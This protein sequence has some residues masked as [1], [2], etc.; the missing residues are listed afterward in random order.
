ATL[1]TLN[2]LLD[3]GASLVLAS[4]LGRPKGQVNEELRMAPVADRLAEL[5]GRDVAAVSDVVG[6]EARAVCDHIEPGEV[7]LLENL[8]FEPG[9]ERNDAGFADELAALADLYGDDAFGAAHR[10]HASVLAL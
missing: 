8:R 6:E 10:A 3:R 1:P 5:L 4:H 2:E 7:V 9:E